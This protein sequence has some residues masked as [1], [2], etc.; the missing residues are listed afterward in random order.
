MGWQLRLYLAA[1]R[2]LPLIAP[3][4]LRRRLARGKEDP[5]RWREKLGQASAARPDGPLI[6]LHAVGLGEV[7][8]G[9]VKLV[10]AALGGAHQ[11]VAAT[12]RAD[13]ASRSSDGWAHANCRR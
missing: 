1:S 2:A 5:T 13:R 12:S 10:V 8:L 4:V 9:A 6:W 7:G 11:T 3:L